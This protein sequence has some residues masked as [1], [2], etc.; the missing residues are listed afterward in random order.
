MDSCR[1][2][3]SF[4]PTS[5]LRRKRRFWLPIF[6]SCSSSSCR[7]VFSF[8]NFVCCSAL[9]SL[10]RA[11]A[12]FA[13]VYSDFM[14]C[15]LALRSLVCFMR[16][17]SRRRNCCSSPILPPGAA[18]EA[19]ELASSYSRIASLICASLLRMRA[20]TP[21]A[22]TPCEV[23]TSDI[24]ERSCSCRFSSSMALA[25]ASASDLAEAPLVSLTVAPC[26][27]AKFLR[28]FWKFDRA[29]SSAVSAVSL[30]PWSLPACEPSSW[31]NVDAL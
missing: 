1:F 18:V 3:V 22:E 4:S 28:I 12:F 9:A 6:C 13:A 17:A 23:V 20:P 27:F 31:P 21:E 2:S 29:A 26:C 24:C 8:S 7:A 5:S 15:T 25:F 16:P 11:K 10:D 30:S 14:L 19:A